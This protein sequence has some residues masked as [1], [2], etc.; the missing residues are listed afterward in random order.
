M[1]HDLEVNENGEGQAIY[2]VPAW[3]QLGT[4]VGDNFGWAEA[5][6]AD[7]S[8]TY[9]IEKVKV[10]DLI[11]GYRA[12]DDEYAALRSDGLVVATGLGEQWTPFHASESYA[13]GSVIRDQA[14]KDGIR[15][16][17]RSLGTLD[18]GRK[19]FMTF[20]LG[21]FSIGD[22]KVNDHLSVN[23]S[24]DSSWKLQVLSGPVIEVCANTVAAARATGTQHF[25]FKHTSGIRDRV[26]S[27]KAAL[28]RHARN[29]ELFQDLGN[30][31]LTIP[32]PG[33]TFGQLLT[34]LFPIGEDVPTKTRNANAEAQDKVAEVY[35]HS[36]VVLG[37]RNGFSVVQAVNT[38]ENWGAPVRRTNGNDERT[39][40]ALRQV[41]ALVSGHQALTEKAIELV[42]ATA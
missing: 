9:G 21:S 31:L 40:R 26:E 4:V 8:I 33:Q 42:L 24:Y 18:K 15:C 36:A 7:L 37:Q 35:K 34:E 17:L 12:Q 10:S 6:A 23:G 41:E 20:D 16:D 1:S 39:T 5:V 13:F 14:A 38:Y 32:V 25:T 3:H 27:A 19:Y 30:Q 11:L 28:A 29:R 22:Y 2:A